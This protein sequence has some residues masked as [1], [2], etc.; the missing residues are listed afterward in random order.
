MV[1]AARRNVRRISLDP[2]LDDFNDISLISGLNNTLALDY[3]LTGIAQGELIFS[4]KVL[5]TIFVSDL[6]G[7][8]TSIC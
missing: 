7:S 8:G 3:R 1:I 4:D 5:D 6:D 2:A